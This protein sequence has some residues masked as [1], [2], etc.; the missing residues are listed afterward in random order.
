MCVRFGSTF[1]NFQ[2][3]Y[4]S[5][6]EPVRGSNLTEEAATLISLSPLIYLSPPIRDLRRKWWKIIP[7]HSDPQDCH[8]PVRILSR[9][10]YPAVSFWIITY[11]Y[12][13]ILLRILFP[14][15]RKT[16]VML[17][18][19]DFTKLFYILLRLRTTY[20]YFHLGLL[21]IFLY[22]IVTL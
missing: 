15:S 11:L 4:R 14:I 13:K 20:S 5:E 12:Y 16:C 9:G 17:S 18:Y 1:A 8:L 6:E 7:H 21:I 10:G 3:N 19:R 22:N 2:G